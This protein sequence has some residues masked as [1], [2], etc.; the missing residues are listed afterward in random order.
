MSQFEDN[1]RNGLASIMNELHRIRKAQEIIAMRAAVELA[2]GTVTGLHREAGR[3]LATEYL[4]KMSRQ[5][6]VR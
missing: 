3:E 6:E 1:V 4:Q 2:G 5:R